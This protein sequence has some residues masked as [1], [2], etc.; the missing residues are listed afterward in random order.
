M[1]ARD[2][3]PLAPTRTELTQDAS[4]IRHIADTISRRLLYGAP[5]AD[6]MREFHHLS[7]RARRLHR[8]A[9]RAAD[10]AKAPRAERAA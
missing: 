9:Q 6:L 10:A 4:A 3:D 5:V 1:K 7:L 8:D 2:P